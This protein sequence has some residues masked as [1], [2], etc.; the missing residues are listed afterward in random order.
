MSPSCLGAKGKHFHQMK[1]PTQRP[2]REKA[3]AVFLKGKSNLFATVQDEGREKKQDHLT[4][5][6][7]SL[8][9]EL[10]F[11]FKAVECPWRTLSKQVEES[12][13][14]FLKATGTVGWRRMG[15]EGERSV[16][17]CSSS[18]KER[19]RGLMWS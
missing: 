3:L 17:V 13:T 9:R 19:G 11:Y 12:D 18:P 7:V 8:N 6:P 5:G 15:G 1:Q 16:R 2:C 14:G 10:G 4:R